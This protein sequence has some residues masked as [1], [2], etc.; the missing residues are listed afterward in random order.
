MVLTVGYNLTGFHDRDF[1]DAQ[2]TDKGVFASL[3]VKF[4]AGS[5]DFLGL[6][7]R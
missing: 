2:S 7:A 6:G 1:S 5:F 3:K 4:D